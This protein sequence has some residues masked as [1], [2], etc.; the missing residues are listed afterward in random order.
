MKD[1]VYLFRSILV[2]SGCEKKSNDPI[3]AEAD[4]VI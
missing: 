3:R 2:I 1:T 4:V